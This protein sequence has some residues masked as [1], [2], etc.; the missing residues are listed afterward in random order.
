MGNPEG[1]NMISDAPTLLAILPTNEV[2]LIG[3]LQGESQWENGPISVFACQPLVFSLSSSPTHELPLICLLGRGGRDEKRGGSKLHTC[4]W[5]G[6]G[7]KEGK[8]KGR[9][10]KRQRVE[11]G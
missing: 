7:G 2:F 9:M 8:K 10:R 3:S 6:E 1:A 11:E 5:Q 4:Y